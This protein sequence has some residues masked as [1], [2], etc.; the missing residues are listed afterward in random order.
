MRCYLSDTIGPSLLQGGPV[1]S[2][3]RETLSEWLDLALE[4]YAHPSHRK[5]L[6]SRGQG[7]ACNSRLVKGK[8]QF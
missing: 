7:S 6:E 5:Q 1:G 4:P 8:Q 3:I 2:L